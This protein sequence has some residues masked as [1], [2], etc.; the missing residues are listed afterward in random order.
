MK[1]FNEMQIM[2]QGEE[3]LEEW[4]WDEA[5]PTGKAI[6][7]GEAHHRGIPHEGVHLWVLKISGPE[8]LVLFQKRA[9]VKESYP[10]CLDITV[11]GHVPFGRSSDKIQK[12][13]MEEIGI[14]PPDEDLVDLGYYRYEEWDRGK[15]HREF[16]RVYLYVDN[17]ELDE[18]QFVDGEVDGI[19]AVRLEDFDNMFAAQM[20]FSAV[21]FDGMGKLTRRFSNR[22]FHPLLFSRSMESYM[23]V[24]ITAMKQIAKGEKVTVSMP[25][26]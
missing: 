1:E 19:Y 5:R 6:A 21:G 8:P 4:D 13:S 14:A 10:G 11:G 16:Q 22:D 17:R 2:K 18:F 9:A 15:H 24:L 23:N 20:E 3:L 25:S 26:L 12:E 7:R